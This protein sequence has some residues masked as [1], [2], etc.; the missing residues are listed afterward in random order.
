MAKLTAIRAC[1]ID[2]YKESSNPIFGDT[3]KLLTD[4]KI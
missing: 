4:N 3:A 1:K 2:K